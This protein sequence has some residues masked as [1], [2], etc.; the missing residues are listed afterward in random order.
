MKSAPKIGKAYSLFR[1][2]SCHLQSLERSKAYV[3]NQRLLLSDGLAVRHVNT[4][5]SWLQANSVT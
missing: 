1:E 5:Q 2:S 3:N 4:Q